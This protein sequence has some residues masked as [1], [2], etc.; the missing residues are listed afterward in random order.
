[1]IKSATSLLSNRSK[2]SNSTEPDLKGIVKEKLVYTVT[3]CLKITVAGS[4]FPSFTNRKGILS[5]KEFWKASNWKTDYT[6]LSTPTVATVVI[7]SLL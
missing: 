1:M 4:M 6:G 2:P 5:Q 7:Y 3:Y